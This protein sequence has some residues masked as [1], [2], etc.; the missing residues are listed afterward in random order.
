MVLSGIFAS[1]KDTFQV[2]FD[3]HGISQFK[4]AHLSRL[5]LLILLILLYMSPT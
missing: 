4:K 2:L 5:R 1:A 3:L